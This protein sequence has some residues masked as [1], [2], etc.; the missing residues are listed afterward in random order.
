MLR[1]VGCPSG[2]P[3][4]VR[5][6]QHEARLIVHLCVKN[7]E[8]GGI[9]RLYPQGVRKVDNS[10]QTALRPPTAHVPE[11][12]ITAEKVPRKDTGGERQ[13]PNPR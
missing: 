1:I 5:V 12:R 8:N 10:A 3:I 2:H 4:V 11:M 13:L 9:R 6:V 7:V